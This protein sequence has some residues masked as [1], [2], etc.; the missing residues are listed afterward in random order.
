M[1][2]AIAE[3]EVFLT[4]YERLERERSAHEPPWLGQR[5][6]QAIGQ[7]EG[8]GFPTGRDEEWRNTPIYLL[9][10]T[11]LEA[12]APPPS[13]ESARELG[14]S[15][16]ADLGLARIVFVNGRFHTGLSTFR[17]GGPDSVW[18]GSIVTALST[19]PAE[20]EPH[21][22]RHARCEKRAFTALNSALWEDGAAVLIPSGCVVEEPI[23]VVHVSVPAAPP[24]TFLPRTLIVAGANCQAS[25]VETYVG[26]GGGAYLTNAVS[27]IAIGEN[28]SIEHCRLQAEGDDAFHIGTVQATQGRDSRFASFSVSLGAVLARIE[29]LSTLE[30]EGAECALNGLYAADGA[31]HVD[32]H[33]TIDHAVPRC[34][35]REMYKGILAG[36]AR[37]VFNGRIIVRPDAQKTDARQTNRNLLL[38][39]EALI[40]TRPQLEI[41][42]NDV[43]C[44]HGATVGQLDPDVMFYLRSRGIGPGDA[45]NL[46]IRAFSAEVTGR[47]RFG[48]LR[49][50]IDEE[51]AVRLPALPGSE[52][53]P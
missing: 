8:L 27:E 15:R 44:T 40:F 36:S 18:A 13:A 28:A 14:G 47:I 7:F 33:T 34:S 32:H 38:S 10:R 3:K 17:E 29:V 37:A 46:L 31:R 21:L 39:D 30:A 11:P 6:R 2:S 25:L 53:E 42:A 51:I 41:F 49:E 9:G 4:A 52:V 12:T 16:L 45:R 50:R 35:S 23:H 22:A 48:P 1:T 20:L 5:R 24:S 19:R 43:K 26:Q